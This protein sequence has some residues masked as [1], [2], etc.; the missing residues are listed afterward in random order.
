MVIQARSECFASAP[1]LVAWRSLRSA[2]SSPAGVLVG[3]RIRAVPRKGP[4]RWSVDA[5]RLGWRAVLR[6][7]PGAATVVRRR[8]AS[9]GWRWLFGAVGFGDARTRGAARASRRGLLSVGLQG[10]GCSNCGAF[11]VE[12][13]VTGQ[14]RSA[15]SCA[16]PKHPNAAGC[17]GD[18]RGESLGYGSART[19][20][21]GDDVW[22]TFA[23]VGALATAVIGASSSLQIK[24]RAHPLSPLRDEQC[25]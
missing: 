8:R 17:E 16:V 14:A 3:P 25:Q 1:V 2:N 18:R 7:L 9:G 24:C 19:L 10:G 20:S 21:A 5:P 11:E 12:R 15:D 6:P 13:L 23:G 4:T 22:A